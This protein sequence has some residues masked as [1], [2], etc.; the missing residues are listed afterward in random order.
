MSV[1]Y[2]TF[3]RVAKEMGFPHTFTVRT[4]GGGQHLYYKCPKGLRF[5]QTLG[6][7]VD[8]KFLGGYVV[9]PPS[10]HASGARYTIVEPVDSVADAP[11]WLIE[12]AKPRGATTALTKSEF[13]DYQDER[14][15]ND[16]SIAGVAG[17]LAPYFERGVR[18]SFSLALGGYLKNRGYTKEDAR[19]LTYELAVAAGSDKPDARAKDAAN[20]FRYDHPAGYS[21][22]KEL[23]PETAL[24]ALGAWVPD[25]TGERNAALAAEL[26]GLLPRAVPAPL[27]VPLGAG[28]AADNQRASTQ[29]AVGATNGDD[30][31]LSRN[32]ADKVENTA[33][34]TST[35]LTQHPAW[36]GVLR[37]DE[38]A[39]RV[40][41]ATEPPMRP[42]DVPTG[43]CVG[44]WTDAHT[45]R[46]RAWIS[47][48][49]GFEPGKD[50]TDS[51]V[52]IA[53][54]R[55][56]YH[57]VREYLASL[58]WDGV[59][60]LD[61]MLARY[62][63]VVE[64]PYASAV[65]S[66][67]MISA[68]A[69][70]MNP[71]SKVDTMLILEGRQGTKKS[72]A[73]RTLAGDAWFADTPLDLESKDAAQCLQGK[74]IYEI[75]ELHSFNRAET[76]RIKAFVSSPVYNLRPSYCRR[77]QEF[78]R[79]RVFVGTTNS[80]EY[81]TD[82]TGNRRY[83]PV[84]CGA[85]DIAALRRGR[86]ALWAEAKHRYSAGEPWWLDGDLETLA[87]GEQ[88]EREAEDPWEQ[89]IAEWTARRS[90]EF[91]M[92]D[93]LEGL[94]LTQDKQTHAHSTRAGALLAKLGWATHR[95]RTDTGRT[96]VY[97]RSP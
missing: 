76:T 60:R 1:G 21:A 33:A 43:S 30:L 70:A 29:A 95:I 32:K 4:G 47:T 90:T 27:P 44:D 3:D 48:T 35:I 55:N 46:L 84:S 38:F 13:D 71:G 8:L 75:G 86:D 54:R 91:T 80:R 40:V 5:P 69:R 24:A 74:W 53:A 11:A 63:G 34:N 88:A 64:G 37:F 7:G 89:K 52:E 96:R 45:T 83:W 18:H 31:N 22:L 61:S 85:I 10:T 81:L 36:Q 23:I 79:Q 57:P 19:R 56:T 41:C 67:F 39:S 82:T 87:S 94:G 9:A 20:A 6:A 15:L 49:F 26:A 58:N 50:A 68:V 16:E 2:E 25:L 65:G 17:L 51:A 12:L 66:K 78:P 92:A 59:P 72:T 28:L 14:T 77:N 42:Q 73:V 97:R 62:F 93:V